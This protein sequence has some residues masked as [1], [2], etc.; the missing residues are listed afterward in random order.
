MIH[1]LFHFLDRYCWNALQMD[2]T[3]LWERHR[4]IDV[5]DCD[6]KPVSKSR[7]TGMQPITITSKNL[8]CGG[9]SPG[10]IGQNTDCL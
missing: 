10:R 8:F 6:A 2:K 3:V 1:N 7:T 9:A 5:L 4:G